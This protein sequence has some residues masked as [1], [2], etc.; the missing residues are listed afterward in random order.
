MANY[1]PPKA[2]VGVNVNL[3]NTLGNFEVVRTKSRVERTKG[4][5]F[6]S[7]RD[8]ERNWWHSP[9]MYTEKEAVC[10]V[11]YNLS[12]ETLQLVFNEKVERARQSRL[13]GY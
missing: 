9:A 13:Q 12:D 2:V 3:D 11:F 10:G 7:L 4:K 1:R 6:V 5:W 8:P